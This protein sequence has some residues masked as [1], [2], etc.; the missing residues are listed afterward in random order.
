MPGEE[1]A[2]IAFFS[3]EVIAVLGKNYYWLSKQH[4]SSGLLKPPIFCKNHKLI[5]PSSYPF[6]SYGYMIYMVI[7]ICLALY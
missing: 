4:L 3:P 2:P 7:R 6:A 1:D 5:R